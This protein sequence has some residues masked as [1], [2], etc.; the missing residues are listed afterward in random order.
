MVVSIVL[1][2]SLFILPWIAWGGLNLAAKGNASL[3]AWVHMDSGENRNLN[4]LSGTA[5]IATITTELEDCYNDRVPFRSQ[6]LALNRKWSAVLDGFYVRN[7][8]PKLH[9][10]RMESIAEGE[11]HSESAKQQMQEISKLPYFAPYVVNDTVITGRDGW[12]FFAPFNTVVDYTGEYQWE[13]GTMDRYMALMQQLQ[14]LCDAKGI[15]LVYLFYPNKAQIYS[16]YMPS[17]EIVDSYRRIDRFVDY[18]RENSTLEVVYPRD[19]LYYGKQQYQTYFRLDTHYTPVG[20][21]LGTL[22]LYRQLGTA[23]VPNQ[24]PLEDLAVVPTVKTY[25]DLMLMAGY[26]DGDMGEDVNYYVN[27]KPDVQILE[28]EGETQGEGIYRSHSEGETPLRLTILG[29]SFRLFMREY[30]E[31]DFAYLSMEC[32][33][34]IAN[35]EI[36]EDVRNTDVL[37]VEMVEKLMDEKLEEVLLCTIAMLQEE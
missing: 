17:Y 12:L 31:K 29:D 24:I 23:I 18:L 19:D 35:T 5:T 32:T 2:A 7:V 3:D 13:Q 22:A 20:G 21:Y 26:E 25:G 30:L 33:T 8:L 34:N 4:R 9:N 1:F 27:Y 37:V 11:H 36:G 16:E 15:R 28:S 10:M 14:D 6:L